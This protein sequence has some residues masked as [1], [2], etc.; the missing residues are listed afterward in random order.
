MVSRASIKLWD[1]SHPKTLELFF[2]GVC[3]SVHPKANVAPSDFLA[4]LETLKTRMIDCNGHHA[5]LD[6]I[7]SAMV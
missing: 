7:K 1:S 2:A 5:V 3:L 6:V 4:H